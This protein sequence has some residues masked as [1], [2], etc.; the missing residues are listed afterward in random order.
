MAK[1]PYNPEEYNSTVYMQPAKKRSAFSGPILFVVVVIA[2][3]FVL[4]IAF[5][6]NKIE[7]T[8][9][10]HYSSDEI[11]KAINIEQGD[12]LFFFDQ[13]GAVSRVF[14]KLPY[15]EEVSISRHL[16]DRVTIEIKESKAMAYLPIGAELWTMDHDC[17]ILGNA[18]EGEE[19]SLIQIVGF[20]P[21]TLFIGEPLSTEDGNDR[22]VNFLRDILN[23]IQGRGMTGQITK[24]DF[25]DVNNVS[26]SYGG[27]YTFKLGDPYNTAHKFGMIEYAMLQLKEGDIG[28]IDVSSD[29]NAE[30]TPY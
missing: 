18:A 22:A 30:F 8:G 20:K 29:V 16:P 6:I 9:N 13:F 11:I 4:S 19:G 3:I 27:K 24:I 5:R 10:G 23:Q 17:K 21:G 14:A 15:V 28:I 12:N 2:V 7:V 25:T 1:S 26:V